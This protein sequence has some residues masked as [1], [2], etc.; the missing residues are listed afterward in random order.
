LEKK[1]RQIDAEINSKL[2]PPFKSRRLPHPTGYM[3][4]CE[5]TSLITAL[6]LSLSLSI[7]IYIYRYILR[8]QSKHN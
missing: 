5:V 8:A 2:R 1:T 6:S 4:N 3:L 7:H